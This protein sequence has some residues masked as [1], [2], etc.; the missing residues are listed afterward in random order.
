MPT[1]I[2]EESGPYGRASVVSGSEQ[3]RGILQPLSQENKIIWIGARWHPYDV[4]L[5]KCARQNIKIRD[6]TKVELKTKSERNLK[7]SYNLNLK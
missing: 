2:D 4:L 6:K 3:E 1:A 7:E 5:N